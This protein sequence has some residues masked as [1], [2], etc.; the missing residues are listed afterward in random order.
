M[1]REKT[2]RKQATG[3]KHGGE[4]PGKFPCELPSKHKKDVD[5]IKLWVTCHASAPVMAKAEMDI[6]RIKSGLSHFLASS[7]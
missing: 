2:G 1:E 3:T 6:H 4:N 5:F 7:P